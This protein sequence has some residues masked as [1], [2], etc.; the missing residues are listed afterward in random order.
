MQFLTIVA[1]VGG[2]SA[3]ARTTEREC[4][5]NACIDEVKKGCDIRIRGEREQRVNAKLSGLG[6]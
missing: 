2:L 1:G 3:C 4:F 6:L 5:Q